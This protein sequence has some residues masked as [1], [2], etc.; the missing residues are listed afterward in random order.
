MSSERAE[1]ELD[2]LRRSDDPFDRSLASLV[3]AVR[4]GP[5]SLAIE[6]ARHAARAAQNARAALP[7]D[8][9]PRLVAYH[10]SVLAVLEYA[11]DPDR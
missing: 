4:E 1:I 2:R 10:D 8:A 9:D 11:S 3:E 5:N 7:S 6:I